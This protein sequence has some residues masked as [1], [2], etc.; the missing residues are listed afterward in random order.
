MCPSIC[1][2][3]YVLTSLALTA[4]SHDWLGRLL[5]GV[6]YMCS[7]KLNVHCSLNLHYHTVSDY[8]GTTIGRAC[9]CAAIGS[10]SILIVCI[11]YGY[12]YH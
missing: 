8:A 6:A 2:Y 10:V 7:I 9:N 12:Q 11:L 3:T 5:K 1:V 4:S